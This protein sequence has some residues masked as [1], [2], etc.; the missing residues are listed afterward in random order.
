[1][2]EEIKFREEDRHK[3]SA[4]WRTAGGEQG[5]RKIAEEL[6]LN[7]PRFVNAIRSFLFPSP[8]HER[9]AR[10]LEG[11]REVRE[12]IRRGVYEG[13]RSGIGGFSVHAEHSAR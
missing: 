12:T 5:C 8:D 9:A 2:A 1:M 4:F 3:W 13:D 11:L 7:G 6:G 10:L